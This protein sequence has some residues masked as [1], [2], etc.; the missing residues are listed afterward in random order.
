[1]AFVLEDGTGLSNSNAYVDVPFVTSYWSDRGGAPSAWTDLGSTAKQ[2]LIVKACDYIDYRFR[3]RGYRQLSTQG[4]EWPRLNA[5]RDDGTLVTGIPTEVKEAVA[6]YAV[7]AASS[8]L[9]PDP[10]YQDENALLEAKRE[11]VGPIETEYRFGA[12]GSVVTFRKYP[13]ADKR[14]RELVWG[15]QRLLRA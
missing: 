2:G 11:K 5:K 10:V 12:A 7:R 9:A 14:V 4:M 6:E 13:I 15:G 1:M 3:W 8:D